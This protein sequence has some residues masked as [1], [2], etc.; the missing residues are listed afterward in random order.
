MPDRQRHLAAADSTARLALE[1]EAEASPGSEW[2]PTL[3]FYAIIH[4]AESALADSG[5]HPEGHAARAGAIEDEWGDATADLFEGLRD[6]S[7]QWRYSGRV[8]T[9]SDV[10]AAKEWARQLLDAAG[11][12]WPVSGF[13]PD[14]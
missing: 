3:I 14:G 11:V 1:L 4:L 6:L 5:V 12:E 2:I 9:A 8:P 13:L 10:E 7:E